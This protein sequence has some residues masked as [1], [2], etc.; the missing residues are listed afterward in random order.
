MAMVCA[1]SIVGLDY[2]RK[3]MQL[4]QLVHVPEHSVHKTV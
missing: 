1:Q 3:G 2:T 4:L